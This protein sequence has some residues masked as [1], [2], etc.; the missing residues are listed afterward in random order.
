MFILALRTFIA[1]VFLI[2]NAAD[3]Q[4][5]NMQLTPVYTMDISGP[6][7]IRLLKPHISQKD[8]DLLLDYDTSHPHD[9]PLSMTANINRYDPL[10][11]SSLFQNNFEQLEVFAVMQL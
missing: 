8:L 7:H 1:A 10:L 4:F 9:V 2:F 11:K 3:L 5:D 6:N